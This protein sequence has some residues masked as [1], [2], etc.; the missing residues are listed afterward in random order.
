MAILDKVVDQNVGNTPLTI[1]IHYIH[2][3]WLLLA[4]FLHRVHIE[5]KA[6]VSSFVY[7]RRDRCASPDRVVICKKGHHY[8]MKIMLDALGPGPPRD[9][10]AHGGFEARR[11]GVSV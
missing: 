5:C 7:S 9:G 4:T 6:L 10:A 11:D 2:N 3:K 8:I 1:V